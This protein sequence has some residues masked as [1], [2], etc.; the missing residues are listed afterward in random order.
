MEKVV[1]QRRIARSF[2]IPVSLKREITAG[3]YPTKLHLTRW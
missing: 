3:A 1:R 2:F